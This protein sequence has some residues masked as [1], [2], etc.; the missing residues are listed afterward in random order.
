MA[1]L[2]IC[3]VGDSIT[4]G[5]GDEDFLGWPGRLCVDARRAGHDLTNYNLG[6]RADTSLLIAERWE[7]E[8][9]ARL[10]EGTNGRLIFA[11]GVN[12]TAEEVGKGIRIPLERSLEI[13]ETMIGRAKAW[14]PTLW[15]GP[16][17]VVEAKQ[18]LRPYA[19]LA[20]DF[21]NRR[22]AE[23]SKAYAALAVRLGVPY[24]EV[25]EALAGNPAWTTHV[26][27]GDGVHPIAQGYV[28][29]AKL[30]GEWQSWKALFA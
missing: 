3:F 21:R 2:R 4:N 30:I 1:T 20:Y 26:D 12:D 6:V 7:R 8:C 19:G 23:A 14:K 24:L 16:A 11:F 15:I 29:F 13:A 22:I 18:P 5:T 28:A 9:R 25:F 10:P 17:P 27:A